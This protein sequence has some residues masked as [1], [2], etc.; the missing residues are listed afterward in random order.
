[1]KQMRINDI[2]VVSID[3]DVTNTKTG[4]VL[5]TTLAGVGYKTLRLGCDK[6]HYIHR[7]VANAFLPAPTSDNCVVDHIDRNK[8]NNHASNLRWVSHAENAQNRTIETKA[9]RKNMT[10]EHHIKISMTKGQVTPTYIVM[11]RTIDI[12][13]YSIHKTMDEAIKKR[14]TVISNAV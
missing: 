8:L 10:G 11:V 5:K 3:G 13:H 14:D 2:Y 6:R 7:L 4:R 1:M 12:K 9:R